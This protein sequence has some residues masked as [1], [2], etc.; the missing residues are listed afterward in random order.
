MTHGDEL[1]VGVLHLLA[2]MR[3]Q[4]GM[5]MDDLAAQAGVHRTYIGLLERGERQPTLMV[6]ADLAAAL[7]VN[8]SDLV[9]LAEQQ[10][11]AP[12]GQPPFTA[13]E[14]HA[15]LAIGIRKTHLDHFT[16]ARALQKLTGIS[17]SMITSAVEAAYGTLDFIDEPLIDAGYEPLARLIEYANL[18]SVLGNLLADRLVKST[19]GAYTRS[20]PHKFLDLRSTNDAYPDIELSL[21]HI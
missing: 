10:L 16:G 14:S 1:A 7:G 12:A 6:A 21:I 15:A 3:R 13:P 9:R 11:L 2:D 5:S 8:L 19:S 20:G 18:S 17:V 4:R